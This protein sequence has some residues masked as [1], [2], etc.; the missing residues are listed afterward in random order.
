MPRSSLGV[1]DRD[2]L[3]VFL[4]GLGDGEKLPFAGLASLSRVLASLRA[5]GDI[6]AS[7][8]SVDVFGLGDGLRNKRVNPA[9]WRKGEGQPP[10]IL[11][12]SSTI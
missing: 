8:S 1:A 4:A 3:G 7:R 5:A 12:P 6:V 2:V 11:Q 9:K 10:K